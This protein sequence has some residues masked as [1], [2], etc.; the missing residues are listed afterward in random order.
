M[1]KILGAKKT[2]LSHSLDGWKVEVTKTYMPVIEGM[3][4]RGKVSIF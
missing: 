3:L 4:G 1:R 2:F